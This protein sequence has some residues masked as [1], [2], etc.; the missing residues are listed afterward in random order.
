MA[1]LPTVSLTPVAN[2]PP[3]STKLLKLV[4]KFAARCRWYRWQICHRCR[5]YWWSTFSCEYLREFSKNSKRP[6]WYTQ[7][8][9]GNWFMK[10]TRSKNSRDTVHLTN[11]CHY[12]WLERF[13]GSQ[14]EDERVGPLSIY[15]ILDG[16]YYLRPLL[17][18]VRRHY[19]RVYCGRDA[20]P[21]TP[22]SPPPFINK[23][24][25]TRICAKTFRRLASRHC[26]LTTSAFDQM[27]CTY[28]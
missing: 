11:A 5:W 7:G 8:L 10:K 13:R 22:P 14:K 20:V 16:W 24:E 1:N 25:L 23:G 27:Y 18:S 17:Y 21:S 3:E 2:L 15:V 12:I 9:G 6:Y 4:A 19:Q 26:L 28:I